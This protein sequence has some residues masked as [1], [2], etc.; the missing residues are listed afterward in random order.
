MDL[1][2]RQALA[3]AIMST[4]GH[5]NVIANLSMRPDGAGTI[6]YN[7]K[8]VWVDPNATSFNAL[9]A[10][11]GDEELVRAY[12]LVKLT[13][14]A[15]VQRGSLHPRSREGLQARRAPDGQRRANRHSGQEENERDNGTVFLHR[16]QGT[17]QVR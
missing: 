16:V 12:L 15:R 8:G 10:Q 9:T 14:D 1:K 4:A 2:L 11:I 6:T 17:Q 3:R 7:G 13:F 5:T